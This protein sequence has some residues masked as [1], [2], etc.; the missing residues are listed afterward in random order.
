MVPATF[1]LLDTLPLANGKVD[2]KALPMPDHVRQETHK[3]F[4]A[5]RTALEERLAGLWRELLDV[6]RVGIHD[7]FYDLGGNSLIIGN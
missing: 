1:V 6:E 2:R 7:D 4:E 3:R 5:P